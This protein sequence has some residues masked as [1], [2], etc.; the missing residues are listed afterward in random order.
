MIAT[1]T[2]FSNLLT[3]IV[4]GNLFAIVA[5]L[6]LHVLDE[7]ETR[8]NTTRQWGEK[9]ST[10]D[11]GHYYSD[12]HP[13][14]AE[15]AKV[16]PSIAVYPD[17]NGPALPRLDCG[18]GRVVLIGDAGHPHGESIHPWSDGCQLTT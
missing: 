13:V 12:W 18:D 6:P 8:D 4:E 9:G 5:F 14:I 16:T 11:L 1:A 2:I 15:M 17:F 10:A 3:E 7:S